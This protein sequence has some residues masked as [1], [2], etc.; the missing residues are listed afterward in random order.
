MNAQMI[1][2]I[3]PELKKKASML[4][5]AEGKN[6]SEI[7]RDLLEEYVKDRNISG[8]IDELWDRIGTK[9]KKKGKTIHDIDSVISQVRS[10]K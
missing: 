7:V 4:A 5:M 1:V 8:Y 3:D 6:I 2:R 9:M 10:K